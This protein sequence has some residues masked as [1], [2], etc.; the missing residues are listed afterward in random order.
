M[1]PAEFDTRRRLLGLSLRE[2]GLVC[3][4]DS[5]PVTEKSVRRWSEGSLDIPARA[6]DALIALEERIGEMVDQTVATVTARSLS[7]PIVLRRYRDQDELDDSPDGEDA[8]LLPLGAHA[9]YIGWLADALAADG[10]ATQ[11]TWAVGPSEHA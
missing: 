3:H 8:S 7:G 2:T 6:I 11:I 1:T 10:V 5:R 4:L 9:I